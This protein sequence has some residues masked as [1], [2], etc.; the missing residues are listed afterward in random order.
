MNPGQA[1][2]RGKSTASPQDAQGTGMTLS[3]GGPEFLQTPV[4]PPVQPGRW[5]G[6]SDQTVFW[7]QAQ[8]DAFQHWM[9]EGAP[10]KA[11]DP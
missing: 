7:V 9:G 2:L 3:E 5:L 11:R 10:R 1:F 8:Y 6:R 4:Q